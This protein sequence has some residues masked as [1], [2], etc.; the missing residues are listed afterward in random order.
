MKKALVFVGVVL[1]GSIATVA[2]DALIGVSFK[3]VGMLAQVAHKTA[4]MVWGGILIGVT[5]RL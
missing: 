2:I 5:R 4:Y 1:L 3:D